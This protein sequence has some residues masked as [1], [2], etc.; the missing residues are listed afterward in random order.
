LRILDNEI[1]LGKVY[2]DGMSAGG[3]SLSWEINLDKESIRNYKE[4]PEQSR[5]RPASSML[6][7]SLTFQLDSFVIHIT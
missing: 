3:V 6:S 7:D 5:E 4:S 1:V 2:K